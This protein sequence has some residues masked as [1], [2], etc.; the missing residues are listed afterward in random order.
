M[1][2]MSTLTE[3]LVPEV[4]GIPKDSIKI[5]A[6]DPKK[7]SCTHCHGDFHD[8]GSSKCDLKDI[9]TKPARVMARKI[10]KR[11]TAGE[12]DKAKIIKEV[13]EAR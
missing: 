10:D 1:K 7:Y 2:L 8:G 13:M 4:Y 5:K 3:A 6:T 12:T 11:I 9:E